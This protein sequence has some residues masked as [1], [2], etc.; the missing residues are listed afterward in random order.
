M[1]DWTFRNLL[2]FDTS[3]LLLDE[4][5][6]RARRRADLNFLQA[7]WK[8]TGLTSVRSVEMNNLPVGIIFDDHVKRSERSANDSGATLSVFYC[9]VYILQ[10]FQRI[11]SH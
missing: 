11:I 8:A 10:C 2:G 3:P 9:F 4:T 6:G 1:S 5:D 7:A